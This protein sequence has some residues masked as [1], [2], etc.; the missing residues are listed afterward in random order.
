MKIS[1]MK[2]LFQY[3]RLFFVGFATFCFLSSCGDK[4]QQLTHI[5]AKSIEID[6]QIPEDTEIDSFISPFRKHIQKEMAVKL[7][8][9]LVALEKGKEENEANAA[10][11]NF[12]ADVSYEM[13]NP[14]Y[15]KR[16]G[17][18]ID[19]VLLNWG[20]I[21]SD[22][23]QGEVTIGTAYRL[24]P[25]ENK[26]VCLEI[27]GNKVLEI[28]E[29]LHKGKRPHPISKQVNLKMT[30]KGD[31][32]LFTINGKPL[33]LNATYIV[34]TSDYLM[35]MG[36]GMLF[37][38]DPVSVYETDYAIRNVLID[39]FTKVDTLHFTKDNRVERIKE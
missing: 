32:K 22:L 5:E 36:D 8:Y 3:Q 4:K 34:A 27:K 23:P 21:R 13:L 30:D 19:F 7:A 33:D 16:T 14:T 11:A 1:F 24:M 9:N 12:M 35:H 37:F 25:F 26:F 28:A 17:K 31:V 6:N 15:F 18:N 29:Y 38:Q 39:Y 2:N 10:I 20:G